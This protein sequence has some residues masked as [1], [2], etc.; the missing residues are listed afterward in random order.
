MTLRIGKMYVGKTPGV[1]AAHM[2][3]GK[4]WITAPYDTWEWVRY[5][6]LETAVLK[7]DDCFVVLEHDTYMRECKRGRKVRVNL[8]RLLVGDFTGWCVLPNDGAW[9]LVDVAKEE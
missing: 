3:S 8:Y 6:P 2:F 9:K 5:E 4:L 1:V 7:G